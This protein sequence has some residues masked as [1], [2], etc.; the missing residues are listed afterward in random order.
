MQAAVYKRYG[1]PSVVAV[2]DVPQPEPGPGEI[3]LRV[4]AAAVTTADWRLRAAAF[5]GILALPGRLMF[6]V[7][8]PR[9]PILGADFAGEVAV[10]G[11]EVEGFTVGQRVFG[12]AGL[13]AHAEYL[14][15]RADGAVVPTPDDL[16]DA[17]AAALP[18]GGLAAL[19][20]LR[21]VAQLK[22]G[23]RVL[24]VGATGGVGAYATQIARAMKAKVTGVASAARAGLGHDLGA[25]RMID[26]HVQPVRD[27]GQYDV[28]LDTVGA[29]RPRHLKHLLARD[30]VFVPLNFEIAEILASLRARLF[31]GPQV[32]IAVSD[33][34]AADLARLVEMVNDGKLRPVIDSTFPLEHIRD[35]YARVET[36]SRAGATVLTM[37]DG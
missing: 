33:D 20:F 31:G 6:G 24:I 37:P 19:V 18:F 16:T 2:T 26:R 32:R 3:L 27:W 9:K 12:S 15:I 28:V 21:D 34:T 5:P 30:G 8:A 36:R 35:A 7:T 23:Q 4:R 22:G 10:L 25:V 11:D 14:A 17:E 1:P 13:G 29:V